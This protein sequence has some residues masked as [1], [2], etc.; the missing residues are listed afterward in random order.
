MFDV[1]EYALFVWC[2]H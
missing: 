2:C 1:Q